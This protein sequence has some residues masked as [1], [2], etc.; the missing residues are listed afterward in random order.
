MRYAWPFWHATVTMMKKLR[1][2]IIQP[3]RR[4]MGLPRHCHYDSIFVELAIP[5]MS[6]LYYQ[7]AIQTFNRFIKLPKD[8]IIYDYFEAD[9]WRRK[10]KYVFPVKPYH[11][12][13]PIIAKA[14]TMIAH[15]YPN[16]IAVTKHTWTNEF[17]LNKVKDTCIQVSR[18]VWAKQEHGIHLQSLWKDVDMK[19]SRLLPRYLRVDDRA[20]A[21]IRARMRHDRTLVKEATARHYHRGRRFNTICE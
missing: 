12:M 21:V 11:I 8:H 17:V 20:T 2:A 9:D 4:V 6:M 7:S 10:N 13:S 14:I 15:I 16:I 18:H 3:L 1:S 5:N 19:K